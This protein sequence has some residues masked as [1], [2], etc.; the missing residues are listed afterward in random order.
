MSEKK[1]K[2]MWVCTFCGAPWESE[3]EAE[4]CWNS[5]TELT[6]DYIWSG[7]GGEEMPLEC[8]IKKHVRGFITKI[9]VYERKNVQEVKIREKRKNE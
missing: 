5:H 9:A 3:G 1:A 8:I 2:Q 4:Q 6:I 7:I